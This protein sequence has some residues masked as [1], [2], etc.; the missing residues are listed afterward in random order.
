[1]ARDDDDGAHLVF[2]YGTLKRGFPNHG[3]VADLAARGDAA[4][5]SGAARTAAP[6][7]HPALVIGPWAVPFLLPLPGPSPV[8]GEL[9]SLSPAPSPSSTASRA[10]P[11]PSTNA[12]PS[13]SPSP[14]LLLLPTRWWWWR[15]RRTTRTGATR[16]RCGGGAGSG[17]RRGRVH[18]RRR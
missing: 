15:R 9:L 10:S 11:S 16:R 5:V 12:A 7:P 4:L 13:P 18:A 1:M 14:P 8:S 3:V 17:D 2:V 6:P